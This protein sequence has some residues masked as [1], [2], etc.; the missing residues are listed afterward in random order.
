M[1]TITKII[2]KY[3]LSESIT[4]E[5]KRINAISIIGI[6][7]MFIA[8]A[9]WLFIG[10]TPA[11][12]GILSATLL[13]MAVTMYLYNRFQAYTIFT[14]I[15]I[16]YICFIMLPIT[17]ILLGN[18]YGTSYFV[19]GIVIIVM[20]LRGRLRILFIALHIVL[21]V[22]CY[23]INSLYPDKIASLSGHSE[24]LNQIR[25]LYNILEY[26]FVS[27][28]I[29]ALMMFQS[30]LHEIERR[31]AEAAG[32]EI[33]RN[34]K[35]LTLVNEAAVLLLT[36]DPD[37]FEAA[38]IESMEKMAVSVDID[39][40]YI[41][42]TC[43]HD[44]NPVYTQIYGWVSPN[45]DKSKTL[46]AVFGSKT[47]PRVTEW[48]DKLFSKRD[49]ISEKANVFI[50]DVWTQFL[51][52]DV[53]AIMAFPIFL[54]N[55]YWGFVSFDN[56][57]SEKLCSEREAA[58]LQSGSLLLANAVERNDSMNQM[59]KRLEQQQLM[60]TI[61]KNFLSKEDI[62][63]IIRGALDST[64]R[65]LNASRVFIAVP[66]N[67]L[68]M[69]S[70]EYFWFSDSQWIPDYSKKEF[71]AILKSEF[72]S[73]QHERDDIP[74]IYCDNT[75]TY[76]NG[77]YKIFYESVQ[78]KA[79]IWEPIYIEDE[80]WGIL[81]IEKC[82][83]FYRWS[84]SDAQLVS[85][86][87][88]AISNLIARDIIEKERAAALKQAIDASRAKSDFLSN[89][90]HEIRTPM[91]AIIGMTGIG[92]LSNSIE[93]K[94]YAFNKI[95]NASKHLLGVINNILDMS[96]IEANKLELSPVNFEFEVMLKKVV[97]IINFR[98]DERHQKFY[99]NIDKNIPSS[100]IGDDRWLAQI[101]TNLL[102]NAVKFT[103]DEGEIHLNSRLISEEAGGMCRLQIDITDTGIGISDE[104]KKRL[105]HSFE[106]AEAN[107]SRK[108]GGTGLGLAISKH[109]VELMGG[110]I[111]V[112][113]EQGKGSK[114]AF[115][116]LLKR[117]SDK[118][119]PLLDEGVNWN[120]IR[121]FTV[122]DEPQIREFF[123]NVSANLGI[124]CVVAA[125]GEEAVD[126]LALDDHY[127]FYFI[128]WKLPG[129]NGIEL[130][131]QIRAKTTN[132][133][134]ITI[135]SSADRSIIEDNAR[136]AGVDKFLEKPL[137]QSTIVDLLNETL[138]HEKAVRQTKNDKELEDFSMHTI[139]LVEDMEIN[140]EIMMAMMEP[141]NLN[142]ECAENGVVA[143][144]MFEA[145]P[146]KYDIIFMDVQMPEMD[147]YETTQR[148]RRLNT[149][150]AKEIP[151]IAMTANVFRE[152]IEQCLMSGMNAHV[153]KPIDFDEVMS[154]LRKYLN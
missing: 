29:S 37:K 125:S 77:K 59:N 28:C 116:V 85:T 137:F 128:D 89:M 117:D 31:K 47:I 139:L 127:N 55:K 49:Y 147:G 100:L 106:Q 22:V 86:V 136:A 118:H 48:D 90:S 93:K 111:W 52:C 27:F 91:N 81:I 42:R 1:K 87:S 2:N 150:R 124:D 73:Y 41:W 96:K 24:Y 135:F 110:K 112:E 5:A 30:R 109:I 50:G 133:S 7:G 40:V 36:T 68:M 54:Q 131:R 14:L 39:R 62:G 56:C 9:V 98:V 88:S 53:K 115:T 70:T 149:P 101:I 20:L 16:V 154:M 126:M 143:L 114:F 108:F 113:S 46:E 120:N 74:N 10:V 32:E 35:L 145:S 138:G 25:Y 148:I 21:A 65:F 76:E 45:A 64:G 69:S 84:E 11:L 79:F 104:H 6:F 122:D 75:V 92:K 26:L 141:V 19:M 71:G 3:L 72:P 12:L 103:P 102:S 13:T 60:S 107:T 51:V 83:D 38:L 95:D 130:A 146:E 152:D 99:V 4:L 44:G 63:N 78:V 105:F 153:G 57:H 18:E 8:I 151:I 123:M 97:N 144:K 119:K 61:S 58:I 94:D 80:L 15:I 142:I 121:I 134:I 82:E 33:I 129:M 66:E 132:K 23:Y 43:E 17:S 34:E 140:R 67:D